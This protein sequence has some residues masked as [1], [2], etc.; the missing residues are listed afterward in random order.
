MHFPHRVNSDGT[1]DSICKH[2]FVTVGS[3]TSE[4]DL[5]RLEAEHVCEPARVAYYETLDLTGKRPPKQDS[6][7]R[8]PDVHAVNGRH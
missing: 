3:S 6:E 7:N 5:Q 8:P 4:S 2:C 1:I